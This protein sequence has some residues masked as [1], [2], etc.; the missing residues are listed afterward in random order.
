MT[1][2]QSH[3]LESL[4]DRDRHVN[5]P[6]TM[7]RSKYK[8]VIDNGSWYEPMPL[9]SDLTGGDDQQC[10]KNAI[11]LASDKGELFYVEGFAIYTPTSL[12]V[13]H[14]WVTTGDGN[15]IDPTWD[16]PGVA[17]AGVPFK[18]PFM[19]TTVLAERGINSVL[20]NYQYDWPILGVL[21]DRPD[22]WLEPRG[23]G[24]GAVDGR[25]Y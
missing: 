18:L 8:F 5:K 15:A 17:Y 10:F 4:Q 9:P 25:A 3:L 22:E 2:A 19:L 12:P 11:D 7:K 14:A 24:V 6:P 23:V 16:T 1:P 13:H 20:D 21:G